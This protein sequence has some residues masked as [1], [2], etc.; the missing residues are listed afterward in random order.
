VARSGARNT[1]IRCK[2]GG[3]ATLPGKPIAASDGTAGGKEA[4]LAV[5]CVAKACRFETDV[6]QRLTVS[7]QKNLEMHLFYPMGYRRQRLDLET[8]LKKTENYKK[9][10]LSMRGINLAG[11]EMN[12]R[13]CF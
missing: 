12:R 1:G 8:E 9:K 4:G 11:V 5:N 2:R 13:I 7:H 10:R 6:R 3:Q